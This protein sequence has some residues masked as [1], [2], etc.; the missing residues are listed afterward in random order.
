MTVITLVGAAVNPWWAV[1]LWGS[2]GV[3][4]G[5]ALCQ[6]TQAMLA[7]R[8]PEHPLTT[9]MALGSV[10]A[11]LFTLLA[12][13]VA[14][15]FELIAYSGLAAVCVPLATIDL[16]D[17]RMP[18]KL[19]V[20]A[21]PSL[22]LLFGLAAAVEHNAAA[23]L[24]SLVGMAISFTFYLIIALATRDGLGA[25]DIRLAGLLGLALAWQN[26]DVLLSGTILGLLYGGLVG[27]ALIILRRASRH[28]MIPLGPALIAGAFTALLVPIG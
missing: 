3:L 28:T 17:K 24:R 9:A 12:W 2:L 6:P 22:I 15:R 27:A 25:A 26:W 14:G 23:M 7:V 19:L 1:P 18:S 4:I 11:V 16:I 8:R 20:P 13:R 5:A 21:Y 10:T